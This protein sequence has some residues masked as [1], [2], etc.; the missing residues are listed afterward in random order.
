MPDALK[1]VASARSGAEAELIC[2]R[3]LEE[4]GI[5]AIAQRNIG[6]PEWGGSGGQTVFVDEQDFERAR[7]ILGA[8]PVSDDELTRLS[9]EA[10]REAA[11]RGDLP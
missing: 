9:E 7:E 11:E 3:L 8:Q 2:G 10:G 5:H 1:S 6:G 4:G